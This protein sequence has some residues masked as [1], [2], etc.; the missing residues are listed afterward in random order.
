YLVKKAK[1]RV[2][3]DDQPL[4]VEDRIPDVDE[5][6]L[7]EIDMSNPF[8]WRQGQWLPYFRRL[9]EE[10]P[11]HFRGSSAFGPYWSVTRYEDV[12]TVDKDFETYSA[13]PQIVIGAPPEGLDVDMFIAM[14][15][16]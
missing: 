11:V 4:F 12:L 2:F 15:P 16:P 1:R 8:M 7:T 10:A 13:A 9:R 3:G 14:D 5:V 6:E